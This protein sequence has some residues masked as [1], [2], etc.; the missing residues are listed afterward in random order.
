MRSWGL[1][2]EYQAAQAR[3]MLAQAFEIDVIVTTTLIPGH[4]GSVLVNQ[5]ML[6]AMRPGSV[7]VDLAAANG[8]N[9]AQTEANKV[10][11]TENGVTIIGC[12]DLP[13]RLASMS[14]TLVS[15]QF[16]VGSARRDTATRTGARGAEQLSNV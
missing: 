12:A 9:V 8:G 14:S 2:D 15:V 7:L 4:K 6:N 16:F 10:I 13:R 11:L 1:S 3:L 5:E